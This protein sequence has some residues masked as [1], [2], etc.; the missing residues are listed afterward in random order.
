MSSG[1]DHGADRVLHHW[2]MIA[3]AMICAWGV[4]A[5][6]EATDEESAPVADAPSTQSVIGPIPGPDHHAP[7]I[8]NPKR[9]AA[10]VLQEGRRLFVLM[11]CSGC[12]GGR[13]GGGMGP[14]LRDEIW[15]YGES[16]GQIFDSI[17]QGRNFG[18]PAW[19]TQLPEPEIWKLVAYIQ[20][21]RTPQEPDAPTP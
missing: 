21:L 5:N 13:A 6:A 16:E 18:M 2:M 11:N 15:L 1:S 20:S 14:S 17:A 10:G 9:D 12:H 4:C 7:A 19:G 3:V 8:R